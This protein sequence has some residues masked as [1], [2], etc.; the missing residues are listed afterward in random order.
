MEN[1]LGKEKV[2]FFKGFISDWKGVLLKPKDFFATTPMEYGKALKFASVNIFV[3]SIISTF[4]LLFFTSILEDLFLNPI[5]LFLFGF[6][7]S[8]LSL[9]IGLFI[10]A[11]IFHCFFKM[12]RGKGCYKESLGILSY[13]SV[14]YIFS[15]IPVVNLVSA[16]Y[17]Y[18]IAIRGG[19]V[20]YNLSFGKSTTAVLLPVLIIL[21]L[22]LLA[23]I[24]AFA[25]GNKP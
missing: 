24:V 15:L 11:F 17:F 21:V 20:K 16:M 19:E 8:L 23:L 2:S 22:L 13:S 5:L 18:Y 12:F 4:F 7:F 10:S 9:F 3:Y 25:L 6:I 14:L 1:E